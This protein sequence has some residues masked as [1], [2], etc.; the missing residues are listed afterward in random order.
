MKLVRSWLQEFVDLGNRSNQQVAADLE[1]LGHEVEGIKETGFSSVVIGKI[2]TITAHPEA[3]RVRITTVDTGDKI[4]TII[5]GGPNIAVGQHVAVAL[6]GAQ[7]LKGLRI[8]ERNIRGVTSEGMICSTDELGLPGDAS[9]ILVLPDDTTIG[10]PFVVESVGEAVFDLTITP[11][12]GDAVSVMGL[13]RDLAARY[14]QPKTWQS[15]KPAVTSQKKIN[16]VIEAPDLCPLYTARVLENVTAGHLPSEITG[17]LTAIGHGHYLPVVDITNYVMEELGVP[18]HAFDTD[19]ITG[20]IVVRSAGKGESIELLDGKT[21]QLTPDDLVIADSS[22]PIAL[23]GIM[24]GKASSVTD[25][26]TNVVLEAAS[27]D[28]VAVRRTRRRLALTSTASYRFERG[29]DPAMAEHASDRAAALIAEHCQAKAGPL[30]V[31]GQIPPQK[32]ITLDEKKLNERLG[33]RVPDEEIHAILGRLCFEIDGHKVTVPTWRHDVAIPEDLTEE[34]ARIVGLDNL[35]RIS[36]K[37]A[38]STE[39]LPDELRWDQIEVLKNRLSAAGWTEHIGSSF[40]SPHELS[41]L[42]SKKDNGG[43]IRLANPVSEEAAYLRCTLLVSLAKAIAKNPVFPEIKFFEVGTVWKPSATKYGG[44]V[45]AVTLAW[46]G[47]KPHGLPFMTVP[48]TP[49]P[50]SLGRDF[51]IRRPVMTLESP[52]EVVLDQLGNDLT[53]TYRETPSV[54]IRTPSRFQPAMRDIAILLEDSVDPDQVM[55]ALDGI[56]YLTDIELFDQFSGG[57]LPARKQSQAFHLLFEHPD[58]TLTTK[59]IDDAVA[60][61]IDR[62]QQKFAAT[63]R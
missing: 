34:V 36:L 38:T 57:K 32:Q 13:A 63:I 5:C 11:N 46:T 42:G 33:T 52:L 12:R 61:A 23:A 58:R 51:K 29:T 19:K 48:G 4:R 49:L 45:V 3:D 44:E 53:Y 41:L 50:E 31:A 17:R 30:V 37:P 24:G 16:L 62:L 1:S 56:N 22:G 2:L 8:A 20:S 28:S 55:K 14:N 15:A 7:L 54:T 43:V 18:L 39:S 21:Y 10:S 47:N 40:L 60:V 27:F 35:P 59:E 25:K 9:G 6:P 26:T